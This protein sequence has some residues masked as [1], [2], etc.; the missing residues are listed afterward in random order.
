[1][2]FLDEVQDLPRPV[3]RKLVRVLQDRRRRYRPMGSDI[4]REVAFEIVCASNKP[5]SDLRSCLDEDLFDRLAQLVV[6]I[7]PLRECRDDLADDWGR[8]WAELRRSDSVPLNAPESTALSELLRTDPL[9]GNL[10]DLQRLASLVMA[11]LDAGPEG[12]AIAH[13]LGE[14]KRWSVTAEAERSVFGAGSR[15]HRL[16]AYRRELARWARETYGS[17]AAAAKALDCNEKTLRIDAAQ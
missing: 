12:E 2:L 17:W 1:V 4:E 16:R 9:R 6:E 15:D 7:P 14:W 10:R 11:W 3:Q 8:V 5:A 13:A